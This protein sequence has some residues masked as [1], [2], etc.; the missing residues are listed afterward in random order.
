MTRKPFEARP[1][2]LALLASCASSPAASTEPRAPVVS[3]ETVRD[4]ATESEA[5]GMR[6]LAVPGFLP[7]VLMVPSGVDPRPWV[8]AAHGAGGTPEVECDY[9]AQ[10]TLR[11][12]FVLCLR[13]TR[14][15]PQ[16]GFYFRDHHALDAELTAAIA[17]A[18]SSFPR[19]A[20]GSGLYAG[21]SQGATMGSLIIDKHAD[22]LPYATLIEG[23]QPWSTAL[24][25]A[26]ARRG[27]K[28]VLLACGSRECAQVADSSKRSF[29][30]HRAHGARRQAG[31]LSGAAPKFDSVW[32]REATLRNAP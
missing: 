19:I 4:G 3:T 31:F 6:A 27:G 9:W 23:F 7:A 13:G 20:K 30:A 25:R 24:G 2:I 21:F 29:A 12:A 32:S 16:A 22:E 14:I 18:R 11:R 5:P 8:V 1:I 17:A 10:L 26:F 28:A 15:N